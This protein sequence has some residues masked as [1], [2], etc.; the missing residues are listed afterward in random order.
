M[1]LYISHLKPPNLGTAFWSGVIF[2]APALTMMLT[3]PF[4]GVLADRFGRK[5]MLLRATLAGSVVLAVMG[6]ARSVVQVAL[7]RGLQ[8]MVT[9]Y[10]AAS[11][12]IVAATV[13]RNIA[14]GAMGFL[15]TGTWIGVGIG[16]L[17][18]GVVGE[19]FGFRASF[20][21]TS[22]SLALSALL[23]AIF[24][25]ERFIP[26][27]K[28]GGLATYGELWAVPALRRLYAVSL[29]DS[30]ARAALMPVFPLYVRYLLGRPMAGTATV[31][32]ILLGVRSLAGAIASPR[33]GRLGDRVGHGRVVVVATMIL[34][35]LYAPQPFLNAAWQLVVLHGL[36]GIVGV[37]LVPGVGALFA[38]EAPDGK[39]G[40]VFALESSIDALG[41]TIGPMLGATISMA[42]GSRATFGAVA[43][44]YGLLIVVAWPLRSV[45]SDPIVE[46]PPS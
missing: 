1:P 14:G 43:L 8:G 28:K 19:L 34:A 40:A 4:W 5:P 9:G 42:F 23:V 20:F 44:L 46:S 25:R 7:L 27:R 22:A 6:L 36:I 21:F 11:N 2:A 10:Q 3:A 15:R 17:L 26:P 29:I 45:V 18:G 12:A 13:P 33:V 37:G 41:R 35:V 16:P 39:Q 32:G 38:L 31:T 24:V 30:L